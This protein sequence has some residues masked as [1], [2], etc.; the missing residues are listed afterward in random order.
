M[1]EGIWLA[2]LIG[3]VYFLFEELS[4]H[5]IKIAVVNALGLQ[6]GEIK[7][8]E[9]YVWKNEDLVRIKSNV[10]TRNTALIPL[11]L[12]PAM[13]AAMAILRRP[14]NLV[15]AVSLFA[16]SVITIVIS[17]HE[18]SKVAVVV[19]IALFALANVSGNWAMR[20]L[21]VLWVGA[22]LLILPFVFL[23]DDLRL[24]ETSKWFDRHA[25]SRVGIWSLT[26]EKT[27]DA[28]ILGVGA[29]MTYKLGPEFME[30]A[31]EAQLIKNGVRR[32]MSRHAHN[33]YLQTWYELGAVGALLLAFAGI[34]IIRRIVELPARLQPVAC[35]TFASCAVAAGLSYGMWQTWFMMLF[36]IATISMFVAFHASATF[37]TTKP[38][39]SKKD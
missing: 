5:A 37:G 11:I 30:T 36:A 6:P 31:S 4:D 24:H 26:A 38:A 10:M 3:L 23:V 12:W 29:R 25:K 34:S 35:A 1:T 32:R 14:Y 21:S 22:C 18:T 13:L 39:P 9:Y 28:P 33:A 7:P 20:I 19:G 15:L 2:L 27:L 16:L 17:P 8:V